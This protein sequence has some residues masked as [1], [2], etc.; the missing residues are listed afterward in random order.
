MNTKITYS[1]AMGREITASR[2]ILAEELIEIA[3]LLILNPI[4]S[5][6]VNK[7]DLQF[8]TFVYNKQQDCL[9]LGNGELYNHSDNANVA[10]S[11][12]VDKDGRPKMFFQAV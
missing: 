1:E 6:N 7:T 8:Y 9:V 3:E 2:Q 12:K 5:V 4:D 10:Y 11:V